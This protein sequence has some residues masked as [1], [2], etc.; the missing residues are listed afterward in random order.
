VRPGGRKITKKSFFFFLLGSTCFARIN[1]KPLFRHPNGDDERIVRLTDT[2]FGGFA[3]FVLQTPGP[4][5]PLQFVVPLDI[6]GA[7]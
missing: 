1:L 2:L 4:D 5:T 6:L 3:E 7:V